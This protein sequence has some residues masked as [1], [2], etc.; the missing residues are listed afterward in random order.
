MDDKIEITLVDP[1]QFHEF[2]LSIGNYVNKVE[3][4]IKLHCPNPL[5]RCT[6]CK[7]VIDAHARMNDKSVKMFI[8]IKSIREQHDRLRKIMEQQK[9]NEAADAAAALKDNQ[10]NETKSDSRED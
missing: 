10:S 6:P 4:L 8:G 5:K 7:N 1:K 2:N 9:L 3:A